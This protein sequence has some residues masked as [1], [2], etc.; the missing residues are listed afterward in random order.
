[1]R[2]RK[3]IF[4]AFLQSLH[5]VV[6][7]YGVDYYNNPEFL[8]SEDR[9]WVERLAGLAKDESKIDILNPIGERAPSETLKETQSNI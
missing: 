3:P 5:N 2:E 1:M 4:Q 7:K 8:I 9:K 6:D